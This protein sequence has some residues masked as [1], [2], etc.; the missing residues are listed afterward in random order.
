MNWSTGCRT[1]LMSVAFAVL[2]I[3]G[4]GSARADFTFGEPVN[5]GPTVN[6]AGVECFATISSDGLELYLFDLDFLRPGGLGGMDMWMTRRSAVSAAWGEPANLGP[7]VNSEYDDVKPSISADGLTLYFGSN[8]PGGYGG[9]DLWMSTR[10]NIADDWGKPVNLGETVNS[11]ADEAF[12]YI[13]PDGLELYFNEFGVPRPGGYGESDIWVARRATGDDP[14]TEPVNLGEAINSPYYDSC[15]YLSPDG[16]L[17]F[18]HGWR[19]GGPGPEDMWLSTRSSTSEVWNPVAPL[20]VPINSRYT[21]GVAGISSDGSTFYFCSVRAG[22]SGTVDVWQAPIMPI[23]DF[24]GD[25]VVDDGDLDILNSFMGT[26]E[27]VGDIGPMAWGDGRVD[28]ADL[29]VLMSYWGQE[30]SYP[31]NPRQASTPMPLEEGVPDIEQA[32]FLSWWPGSDASEHD[33]YVGTNAAAVEDADTSDATGVY[34]GRQQTSE[35]VLPE[36]LLPSQ[37]YYWRVDEWTADGILT[38]GELWNFS[39]ANDF[40]YVDDME[41]HGGQMWDIWW[42]GWGDPNNGSVVYYPE[43]NIVHG[44]EQSMYLFYD[45]TAAPTSQ[46]LRVWETQQDWTRMGVETLTL[47]LHG[48]PDNSAEPLCVSLGDSAGNTAVVAHPDPAVLLSDT[49]QEWSIALADVAGVNLAE[50]ASMTIV[51][52]D[53]ATEGSGMGTIYIDDICLHPMSTQ[54]Q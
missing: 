45:N 43:T 17:L 18:C 11:E 47:W 49:W 23:V 35:Y 15:P 7:P 28:E 50:I 29:Q 1:S 9:F 25:G 44:G 14:W 54:G 19:P 40:L 36:D 22:G 41:F 5:L 53:N 48:N 46:V 4:G 33:V 10:A 51:I 27:S 39:V 34:R 37:M 16:L 38:R 8:R 20:P 12:C 42:D 6:S 52:G 26:D 13:S 21:D 24:N 2:T 32:R 3:I 30:V 31:Y